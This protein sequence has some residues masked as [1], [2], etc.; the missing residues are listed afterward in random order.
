MLKRKMFVGFSALVHVVMSKIFCLDTHR[1]SISK[2]RRTLFGHSQQ[3]LT[4]ISVS[5]AFP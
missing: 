3:I 4:L 5:A 1:T 2:G